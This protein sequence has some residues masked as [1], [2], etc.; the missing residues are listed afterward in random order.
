MTDILNFDAQKLETN[1]NK[2][3]RA[4]VTEL[5]QHTSV[6]RRNSTELNNIAS[7]LVTKSQL[8]LKLEEIK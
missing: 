4:F 3:L 6:L 2:N 5:N 1:C 8:L 7:D